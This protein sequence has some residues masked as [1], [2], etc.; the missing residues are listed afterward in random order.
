MTA[1]FICIYP[2]RMHLLPLNS[3]NRC[4]KSKPINDVKE[5]MSTSKLKLSPYKTEFI[6]FGSK[7]QRDKL[8]ACFPIDILGSPFCPFGLFQEFG[9]ISFSYSSLYSTRRSQSGGNFPVIPKFSPSV[10]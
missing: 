2:K 5:W 8:K 7:I 4:L 1:Q 3:L 10:H 6:I 9:S